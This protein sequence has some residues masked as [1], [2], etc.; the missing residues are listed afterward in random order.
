MPLTNLR[1]GDPGRLGDYRLHGRLGAGGMGVVYLGEDQAS[2]AVAVKVVRA[3]LAEDAMFRLRFQREVESCQRV[4]GRC[5]ARYIDADTEADRP[6]LV[7]EFIAGP[8]LAE[9]VERDGP[10]DAARLVGL[11]TGLAEAL[12]AIH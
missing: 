10:L 5:V 1:P 11:A 4:S 6:Y 7:S 3:E 8:S 2:R 12:V 9:T